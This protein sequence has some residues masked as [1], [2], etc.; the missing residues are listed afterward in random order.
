MLNL[1]RLSTLLWG[2]AG[3]LAL[4]AMFQGAMA[5]GNSIDWIRDGAAIFMLAAAGLSFWHLR[6][7]RKKGTS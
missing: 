3:G 2:V 7:A 5:P 1:D 6:A 4:A